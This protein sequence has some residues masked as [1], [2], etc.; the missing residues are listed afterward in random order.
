MSNTCPECGE[1]PVF[2]RWERRVYEMDDGTEET[3]E[4]LVDAPR[5]RPCHGARLSEQL[6]NAVGMKGLP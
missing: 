4:V 3:V 5:C 6:L 2:Q 1:R